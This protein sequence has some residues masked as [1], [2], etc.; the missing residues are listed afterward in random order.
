MGGLYRCQSKKGKIRVNHEKAIDG[1]MPDGQLGA[2]RRPKPHDYRFKASTPRADHG[3][4]GL[5]EVTYTPDMH[6]GKTLNER[7]TSK[8][9]TFSTVMD[10]RTNR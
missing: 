10:Y 1:G 4:Q 6:Q 9:R 7:S 3:V 5:Q 2:T 8:D